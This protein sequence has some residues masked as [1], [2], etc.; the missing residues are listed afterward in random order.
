MKR[1]KKQM[2]DLKLQRVNLKWGR[3][4]VKKEIGREEEEVEEE[5]EE[6]GVVNTEEEEEE[7]DV[8]VILMVTINEP[9]SY[10]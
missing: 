2:T 8:E 6:E 4:E 3:K 10:Q 5:A 9:G 1:M 7:E